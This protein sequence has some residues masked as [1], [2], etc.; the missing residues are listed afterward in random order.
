MNET[1][2]AMAQAMFKSWFVDFDPVIDKA[3]AAGNEIPEELQEKAA[4]RESLGDARKILPE[5]ISRLFPSEFEHTEEMGWIPKGWKFKSLY[6]I[7]NYINGAAYKS[8]HFTSEPDALPVV[9]IAE[10]KN[11]I[12]GQTKFTKT[13]LADKYLIKN[14]NILFSWSGNPDTSID[15]FVWTG[16]PGWL[17]QH[18]FKVSLKHEKDRN[19]IYYQLKALRPVFAEIARDKQTTGLGHVTIQDMKRLYVIDCPNSIIQSFNTYVGIFFDK[20]Y[21]NL[22]SIKTLSHLRDTLLPKLLSGQIRIPEAEKL[23]EAAL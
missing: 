1:L 13:E 6:K 18:I 15:T 20:W 21:E 7:A 14:G 10:I 19:F 2:E 12:S 5:E 9:K 17:N 23:A 3:L 8:F 11:G 16:G 4:V 22:L